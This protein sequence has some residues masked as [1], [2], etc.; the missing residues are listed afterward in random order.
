MQSLL[1]VMGHHED[2]ITKL[3]ANFAVQAN[4]FH[5]TSCSHYQLKP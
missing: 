3:A 4:L 2:V 5:L 1:A